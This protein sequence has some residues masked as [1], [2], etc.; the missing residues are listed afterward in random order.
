MLAGEHVLTTRER[1]EP[2]CVVQKSHTEL[3]VAPPGAALVGEEQVLGVGVR[4]VPAEGLILTDAPLELTVDRRARQGGVG[5]TGGPIEQHQG[6]R[7]ACE[8]ACIDESQ[9]QLVAAVR[10]EA[11]LVV[12]LPADGASV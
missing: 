3:A 6:L 11:V 12:K 10:R 8:L 9:Q 7:I 4:L 2:G 5:S 1:I